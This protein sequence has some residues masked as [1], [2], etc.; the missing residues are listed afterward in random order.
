MTVNGRLTVSPTTDVFDPE[1]LMAIAMSS[2]KDD[3]DG[4][5]DIT[6]RAGGFD[7]VEVGG[8]GDAPSGL[9]M[10]QEDVSAAESSL[11]PR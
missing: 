10:A 5:G 7:D 1:S 4:D 3:D 6:V 9:M 2:R 11:R 8:D